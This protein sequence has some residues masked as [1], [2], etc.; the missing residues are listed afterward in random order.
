MIAAV[1]LIGYI[2]LAPPYIVDGDGAEFATLGTA[3]GVGHPTGY[4]AYLLWLRATAWL[5]AASPAH[6]AAIATAILA[7]LQL[8]VLHA[9][10]RAW[11]ARPT[12]ATFTV[13]L[14]AAGPLVMR[15]NSEAEAFAL[16]QLVVTAVVY[17][18]A[19]NAAVRGGLR[20]AALGL[21]AGIGLAD[22]VTCVLVAPIG[23]LGAIRGVRESPRA[24]IAAAGGIAALVVGLSPYAYLFLTHENSISW[25][26]FHTAGELV[27]HILR[28]AYGGP[29]AFSTRVDSHLETWANLAVFADSVL[30]GWCWLPALAGLVMLGVRC[31]RGTAGAERGDAIEPRI[32]W[33]MLA[34]AFALAGPLLIGRFDIEPTGLAL[35]AVRRFHLMPIVLLAP[36]VAAAFE[37]AVA[38][39][40][41]RLRPL[42]GAAIGVLGFAT[43]AMIALPDLLR[44]RTPAVEHAVRGVLRGLPANAV[45]IAS[46]DIPYFGTGYLQVA[47]GERPDVIYIYWRSIAI[48][49]YRDRLARRGIAIETRTDATPSVQIAEQIL[50][51]GRPLFV[52]LSVG[53]VLQVFPSYPYG[54]LFRVLPRGQPRP[55]LDEVAALNRAWFAALD[56]HYAHPGIEDEFPTMIHDGYAATWQIIAD[57]YAKAGKTSEAASAEKQVQQLEPWP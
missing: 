27:D 36:A 20:V 23:L 16:N 35:Y 29:G 32:G 49:W 13:A 41:A 44:V 2:W 39:H 42:A 52:D 57:G 11:G 38:R 30:R 17:L 40:Q 51:S 24:A 6:T 12:A 53:K 37:L 26:T 47:C 33:R 28:R 21:V 22:H 14:Y 10:C 4:P 34:L 54:T 5:P 7:G 18:A 3:G 50:A 56:L 15:Y 8:V 55:S 9:A 19:R 31:V 25:N 46:G 48:H 45:V 43:A 1:A